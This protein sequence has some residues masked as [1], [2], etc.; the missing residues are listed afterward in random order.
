MEDEIRSILESQ[1]YLMFTPNGFSMW[2]VIR[3]KT[4][5]AHVVSVKGKLKKNEIA[6]YR[7]REH[8]YVLHRVIRV[9]SDG[10]YDFRGDN[11][12]LSERGISPGKVIGVLR[13]YY[14]GEH[15]ISCDSCGFRMFSVVWTALFV[16][17]IPWMLAVHVCLRL[18]SLIKRKIGACTK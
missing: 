12:I 7:G 14:R 9:N 18:G 1:G 4:D 10:T 17:R 5:N 8:H 16:V 6:L 2:P 3:P 13:G 11:R 15:Y